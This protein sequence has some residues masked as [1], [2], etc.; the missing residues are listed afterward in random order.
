MSINKSSEQ[1]NNRTESQSIS[2]E[3]SLA[4]KKKQLPTEAKIQPA[5]NMHLIDTGNKEHAL[6]VLS[7]KDSLFF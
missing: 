5:W 1:Q 3:A 6:D 7:S 4:L 2:E